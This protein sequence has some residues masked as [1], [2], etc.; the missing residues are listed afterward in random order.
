[1]SRPVPG[2][3]LSRRQPYG[4]PKLAR[5]GKTNTKDGHTIQMTTHTELTASTERALP[6]LTSRCPFS[7]VFPPC[8][9]HARVGPSEERKGFEPR[10]TYSATASTERTLPRLTARC[11]LSEVFPPCRTYARVGPSVE[12]KGF[13][14]RL[15]CSVTASPWR[16]LP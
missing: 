14:P 2:G 12:R 16:T 15:T 1:M 4:P 6:R 13:E 3:E 9:I 7:E 8:R 11:L 10:L 5:R